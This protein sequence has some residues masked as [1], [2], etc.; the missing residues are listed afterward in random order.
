[1]G[2]GALAMQ[3]K[4]DFL[5]GLV[6]TVLA[7]LLLSVCTEITNAENGIIA[8]NVLERAIRL[9][10]EKPDGLLTKDDL[11][12]LTKLTASGLFNREIVVMNLDGIQYC[13]NLEELDLSWNDID[14]IGKLSGLIKL[15]SLDIKYNKE[16][17]NLEPVAGLPELKV[18]KMSRNKTSDFRPLKRLKKLEVLYVGR[19]EGAN[20]S[21][22][23]ELANLKEL[24]IYAGRISD[25][26]WVSNLK[27][28]RHL[29]LLYNGITDISPLSSLTE[30]EYLGL[31]INK[32]SDIS[33]VANFKKLRYL[34]IF[35]NQV[36]DISALA[37]LD[38]LDTI[39]LTDNMIS[40]ISSLS[41]LTK[42][43]YLMLDKNEISDISPVAGL[44]KLTNLTL[45]N[46][47]IND[48][49]P[50]KNLTE[51]IEL[52]LDNND[53]RNIEP[54]SNLTKL[55]TL[56]L[57]QN[58]IRDSR[59]LKAL[60]NLK[61]LKLADNKIMFINSLSEM[62]KLE[63]VDISYNRI[64]D[65]SP[66]LD[67][68]WVKPFI[69]VSLSD[70]PLDENS[71]NVIIPSLC[72]KE[73]IFGTNKIE[74]RTILTLY[75]LG[76]SELAFKDTSKDGNYGSIEEMTKEDFIQ[77]G[78]D[79]NNLI[80][81]YTLAVFDAAPSR[82][83][84]DGTIEESTFI[85]IAVPNDRNSNLRIFAIDQ[86]QIICEWLGDSADW[87]SEN[88]N[89]DNEKQWKAWSKDMFKNG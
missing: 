27:K 3:W 13:I 76:S 41:N 42:L 60:H 45:A 31:A 74:D 15:T 47:A 70:N 52:T 46:N 19:N 14:D 75:A 72:D 63:E 5:R 73:I 22:I 66:L 7:G 28:L 49:T 59:P 78:Y 43:T 65:I 26:S 40:D 68:K 69:M 1:L 85:I 2:G 4:P 81:D 10:I 39:F 80:D 44:V 62:D 56:S 53:I 54:I 6:V 20:Y 77:K 17:S 64:K 83:L 8:D 67:Y 82:T 23:G 89:L 33:P 25:I 35:N 57:S 29:D 48:I 87:T 58:R 84:P 9:E 71:K 36:S 24:E 30:L 16:I 50:V 21:I 79:E 12:K 32:I 34:D 61:S 86:E 18:L 88:T 11:A 51:L 37:E 55:E 38:N